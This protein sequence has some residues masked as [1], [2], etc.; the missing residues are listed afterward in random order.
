MWVW[1]G[2]MTFL[3]CERMIMKIVTVTV[4]VYMLR[5]IGQRQNL[6]NLWLQVRDLEVKVQSR[7]AEFESYRQQMLARPESK[8]HAELSILQLEKVCV[9]MSVHVIYNVMFLWEMLLTL[10]FMTYGMQLL[11]NNMCS[12]LLLNQ[13]QHNFPFLVW[14]RC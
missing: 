4:V 11:Y 12:V 5:H 6:L 3:L 8:L 7:E 1:V 9:S 13:E 2:W 14:H 10:S